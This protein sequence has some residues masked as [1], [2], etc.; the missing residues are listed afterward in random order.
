M[1]GLLIL[2]LIG[3]YIWG[4]SKLFKHVQPHWKKALVVIAAI[5]LPT[6]DAVY[7]RIKLKQMC[8]A[9]GGLHVYRVVEGVEGFENSNPGPT[10]DWL[11]RDRYRFIEGN[12]SDGKTYRLSMNSDGTVRQELG[13]LPKSEYR[14]EMRTGTSDGAYYRIEWTVSRR[15]TNEVLG[16]FVNTGYEGGWCERFV[17]RLYAADG[18]VAVCGANISFTEFVKKILKPIDQEQPK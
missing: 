9:E 12:W 10:E 8:E 16:R 3:G 15:D 14:L 4:A 1:G 7:G 2:A 13:V 5:L 11:K 6:A 18:V 17:N